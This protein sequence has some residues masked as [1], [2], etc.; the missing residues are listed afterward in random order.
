MGYSRKNLHL[1]FVSI[2]HI[3]MTKFR[4]KKTPFIDLCSD[5]WPPFVKVFV[6]AVQN[7]RAI[8]WEWN[9]WSVLTIAC[10]F[11]CLHFHQLSV[12]NFLFSGESQ[13]WSFKC[14]KIFLLIKTDLSEIH[15]S[16]LTLHQETSSS[17]LCPD[18][19]AYAFATCSQ[20][21]HILH[22]HIRKYYSDWFCWSSQIV[23][24]GLELYSSR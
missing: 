21:K 4:P 3:I 5:I 14:H 9:L 18:Q 6:K 22:I 12:I 10:F 2:Y 13:P 1:H 8:S 24:C 15:L 11:L 16:P 17:F 20:H 7:I 23:T 19:D